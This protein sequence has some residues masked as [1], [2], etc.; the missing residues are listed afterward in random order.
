YKKRERGK[1]CKWILGERA[2]GNFGKSS[3]KLLELSPSVKLQEINVVK[4]E[5]ESQGKCTK[6]QVDECILEDN[7]SLDCTYSVDLSQISTYQSTAWWGHKHGFVWGGL[8]GS[9][10][11]PKKHITLKESQS[12]TAEAVRGS[13]VRTAFCEQDQENLYNLVQ[14]KAT[15]GK[16][17]LGIGDRPKKI[18]GT[19]WNG[20]KVSF[21]TND[22]KDEGSADDGDAKHGFARNN[23]LKRKKNVDLMENTAVQ[24]PNATEDECDA[25]TKTENVSELRLKLKKICKQLLQEAPHHSM[26][27]KKLK[28]CIQSHSSF[29][30]SEYSCSRD[31]VLYLTRK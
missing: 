25:H 21:D 28:K 4:E 16:R 20:K 9:K 3:C 8:L 26:K 6:A 7:A 15:T 30:F 23:S 14:D 19:H 17:G 10:S 1:T 12:V 2:S 5:S 31:A 18:A 13:A 11:E 27:I 24:I 29:F 22:D